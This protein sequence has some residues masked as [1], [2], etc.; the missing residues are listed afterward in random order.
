M[1]AS[2]LQP[3][4][5]IWGVTDWPRL[6]IMRVV[7]PAGMSRADAP[8]QPD[9]VHLAEQMREAT[10]RLRGQGWKVAPLTPA[11]DEKDV[12]PGPSGTE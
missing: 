4:L 9:A 1:D 8:P 11:P 12:E 2:T 3:L 7:N 5:R 10:E 6:A